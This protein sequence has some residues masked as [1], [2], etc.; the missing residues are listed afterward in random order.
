[1]GSELNP[2]I[3]EKRDAVGRLC[4]EH[5]VLKIEVFGS[6]LTDRFD[7]QSSDLDFVVSFGDLSPGESADAYFGLLE[8]LQELFQRHADLVVE[9]AITNPYFLREIAKTRTLLYAA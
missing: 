3:E 4:R 2:L 8:G 6:A 1:M 9:S 5:H 7:A